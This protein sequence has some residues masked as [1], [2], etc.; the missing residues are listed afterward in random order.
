MI[1]ALSGATWAC[2]SADKRA[3]DEAL[4]H[5]VAWLEHQLGPTSAHQQQQQAAQE[6]AP[7]AQA[8]QQLAAPEAPPTPAPQ[9]VEAKVAPTGDLSS[10]VDALITVSQQNKAQLSELKAQLTRIETKL[11]ELKNNQG[12]AP[13]PTVRPGR[14]DPDA[15]YRVD[16][17]SSHS[18]GPADAKVTVVIFSDFQCPYCKR[19]ES[20]LDEVE[21]RYK[22]DVRFVFRHNPLAFHK[23]AMPAAKAAEAAGRQG[24]FWEMHALLFANNRQLTQENFERWAKELG[25]NVGQFKRDMNDAKLASSIDRDQKAANKVGARGTPAFF[26]NGRHLSGAQPFAKFESLID[27][28]MKEA[29]RLIAKGTPRSRV[30]ATLMKDAKTSV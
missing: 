28:E 25:L 24:K 9:D 11:D 8:E 4:A 19:V 7:A 12:D 17:D 6:E 15:R 22:A 3:R 27:E 30:Y 1:L 2:D 14:P 29:E 21:R 16:V 20:T 26:I 5:R 10:R 18:K 23:D 13:K